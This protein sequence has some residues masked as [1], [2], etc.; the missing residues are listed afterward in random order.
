MN[1][2]LFCPYEK[3]RKRQLA[4]VEKRISGE[5][6]DSVLLVEHEPVVTLGTASRKEHLLLSDSEYR[7]RGIKIIPT[8]RGGDVTY[9]GP[10]QLVVYPI[11]KLREDERDAHLYLRRLEEAVIRFLSPL[12]IAAFRRKGRT[13][14][15]TETGKIAACGVHLRRWVTYHGT[16]INVEPDLDAFSTIVPCGLQDR[17]V[18]SI[19]EC[20]RPKPPPS[21]EEAALLLHAPLEETFRR[22]IEPVY[23]EN[24]RE[25]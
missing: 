20:V 11:I 22:P 6:P 10:G 18:T 1:R 4:L 7:R 13:G 25:T 19:T 2:L 3:A 9:H 16:A 23:G 21:L 17:R 15:W 14:V 24:V 12:G 5:I 8:D